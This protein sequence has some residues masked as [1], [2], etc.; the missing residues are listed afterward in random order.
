MNWLVK[1]SIKAALATAV[2]VA[3]SSVAA[4]VKGAV[5]GMGNR[6]SLAHQR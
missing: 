5:T 3:L 1:L 6:V 4:E 2:C